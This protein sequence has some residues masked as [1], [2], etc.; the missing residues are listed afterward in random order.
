[1]FFLLFVVLTLCFGWPQGQGHGKGDLAWVGL[2]SVVIL[3]VSVLLH[4]LGHCL[5]VIRLGGRINEIV[6]WP[7]GG[8]LPVRVPHEP[9]RELAA[10]LA[11]PLVNLLLCLACAPLLSVTGDANLHGLLHPLR[12]AG[13]TDGLAWA[14]V[15]KLAFWINWMLLILNLLP[16]FPFDGGR[17]VRAALSVLWPVSGHLHASHVVARTARLAAVVL[18]IVAV[19]VHAPNNTSLVPTSF[20]LALLAIFIFFSARHEEEQQVEAEMEES[21][22]GYDFSQGFTSLEREEHGPEEDPQSPLGRWLENRREANRRR[23][24]ENE[25]E[26]EHR[27]DEILARLHETGMDGLSAEDRALLD[28]VSKRYRSRQRS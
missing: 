8:L 23:Q 13:L 19:L 1:M 11:G 9:Q 12:P 10:V 22:F 14:I 16:A 21:E 3:F 4:E 7:L 5:A 26:D 25:A 2:A 17:A 20:A 28:R 27:V 18:L 6:I 15:L 24:E